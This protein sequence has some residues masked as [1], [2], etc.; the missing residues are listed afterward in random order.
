[1]VLS[2]GDVIAIGLCDDGGDIR[3]TCQGRET[4]IFGN[5][6]SNFTADQA[7]LSES[8]VDP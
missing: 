4:W 7:L 3:G 6:L 8:E 1:L 5:Q 2:P